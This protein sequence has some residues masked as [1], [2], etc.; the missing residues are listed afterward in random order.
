MKSI[1]KY[2]SLL[3]VLA[4]ALGILGGCGQQNA[5]NSAKPAQSNAANTEAAGPASNNAAN[6]ETAAPVTVR[7]G[8]LTGP[9][10]MGL[11]KLLEDAEAGKTENKYE[12]KLAGAADELSPLLIKGELDVL[13]GPVNLAA[14]LNAKTEGKVQL[15]AV[16][17]L[18][19]LSIFSGS[20]SNEGTD[21]WLLLKG[22]TI[23]ATGKGLTPEYNL[24][25]LLAKHGLDPDKDVKIEFKS[26]PAEILSMYASS[27]K[28]ESLYF[29]LPQPFASV[30]Q[31]QYPE[32]TKILD[33]SA[34]WDKLGEDS[35]MITACLMV[36]RE[37][38]EKNP[39]AVATL[40][41]EYEASASWVNANTE[42][43]AALTEKYINIK[44]PVAKKALPLCNIVCITGEEMKKAASAYYKVL[45]D[46][47]PASVGGAMPAGSFYLPN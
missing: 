44:A 5:Q 23:Y 7:L 24:R 2:I 34:E 36:R 38:A 37:F 12:Y 46:S 42:E 11:V 16:T 21:P 43:A 13:A 8:G 19:V 1:K 28:K 40:L 29:M 17:T 9:T 30:A 26:E 15:A 41:K 47:N 18:G 10:T 39:D 33:L 14:V 3:L 20:A 27:D 22:Q 4:M 32:L 25:Y 6:T 45:F 35:K 31:T